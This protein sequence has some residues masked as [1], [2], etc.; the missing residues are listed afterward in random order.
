MRSLNITMTRHFRNMEWDTTACAQSW[1]YRGISSVRRILA[2]LWLI[3]AI[4]SCAYQGNKEVPVAHTPGE[5]E[6]GLREALKE[7]QGTPYRWGRADHKGI[8]CSGLVMRLYQDVFNVQLP[9]STK[10]QMGLGR[11]VSRTGLRAGDLVFFSL[12]KKG[13]HVGICL[14]DGEFAHA[15]TSLGVTISS[16]QDPY[17]EKAF[18]MARRVYPSK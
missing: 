8:D 18:M 5:S 1:R 3:S 7:W 11:P 10:E 16:L 15:S 14:N 9:R 13:Y 17:W 4:L 12:R 2:I 6:Q